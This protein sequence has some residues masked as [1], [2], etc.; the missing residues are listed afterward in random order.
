MPA[1][2]MVTASDAGSTGGAVSRR[3]RLTNKGLLLDGIGGARRALDLARI[4]VGL[5]VSCE[6]EAQACR[7]TR[8][9]WP[10]VLEM[11]D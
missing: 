9:A 1:S 10:D 5:F 3:V 11:G 8:Y 2:G 4:N 6:V 7:V